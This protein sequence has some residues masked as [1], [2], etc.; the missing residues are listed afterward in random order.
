MA[1]L[2]RQSLVLDRINTINLV[3]CKWTE[4][5]SNEA[6]LVVDLFRTLET[7]PI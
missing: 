3:A 7:T 6:M 1:G 2:H 4:S 5:V